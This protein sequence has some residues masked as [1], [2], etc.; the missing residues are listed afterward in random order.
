MGCHDFIFS[1]D[2]D[3]CKNFYSR[4]VARLRRT[5]RN[6]FGLLEINVRG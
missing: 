5:I 3:I 2:N 4:H 6:T 1:Y